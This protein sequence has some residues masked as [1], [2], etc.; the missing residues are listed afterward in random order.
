MNSHL[1][2]W[3]LKTHEQALLACD[4]DQRIVAVHDPLGLLAELGAAVIGH[5][6]FDAW[7]E[8]E[9]HLLDL[10]DV[11]AGALP[12]WSTDTIS[13][14]HLRPSPQGVSLFVSAEGGQLRLLL[15]PAAQP[16]ANARDTGHLTALQKRVDL[17]ESRLAAAQADQHTLLRAISHDLQSPLK[18]IS[19]YA[20]M[21]E[22][23]QPFTEVHAREMAQEIA[24]VARSSGALVAKLLEYA[25]IDRQTLTV[26]PVDLS[27][28]MTQIVRQHD[29]DI[30]RLG[31][32]V[33]LS[34]PF[35]AVVTS[36][37]LLTQVLGN[38]ISNGLKYVRPGQTPQLHVTAQWIARRLRIAVADEGIGI[39]AEAA[40]RIFKPFERLHGRAET[41]YGG[42][43]LGL[44]IAARAAHR[45]GASLGAAPR[46]GGGSIFWIDFPEAASK[47]P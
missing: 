24:T 2:E 42:C 20:Q 37:V 46:A 25:R 7:P 41:R 9:A 14:Q 21:I 13:W 30:Q 11:A 3:F 40:T 31:A 29:G 27:I 18:T 44:S 39:P 12:H 17:L 6:L 5:A 38:F 28:L 15:K 22:E 23:T 33:D 16:L 19:V 4:E 1:V 8:L 10:Q 36:E 35:P 45:L 34:G 47:R 26:G 43:G 32:T